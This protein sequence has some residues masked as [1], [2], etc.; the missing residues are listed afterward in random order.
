[1]IGLQLYVENQLVEMFDDESVTLTQTIQDVRN[2]DKIFSDFSKTFSVPASETNNKIFK[3]F[4]NFEILNGF[5]ARVK[6]DAELYLNYKLFK[7]GKV[8]L[9]G[10]T[11]KINKPHTYK[12]TF[13]G[14]TV[15]LKDKIGDSTLSDLPILT[16]LEFEYTDASIKGMLNTAQ[17]KTMNGVV[18]PEVLLVPL[19]THTKRLI[20]DSSSSTLNT[21]T[22]ANIAYAAGQNKGVEFDQLKPAIRVHAI[23]KAIE[24]EFFTQQGFSFSKDFFATSNASYYNL[25]LWLHN[26]VGS[27]FSDQPEQIK[28]T[29]YQRVFN[30]SPDSN[31]FTLNKNSFINLSSFSE[32]RFSVK[33]TNQTAKYNVYLFKN[34]EL[35]LEYKDLVG[36]TFPTQGQGKGKKGN[37]DFIPLA[38]G[39]FTFAVES[40][41]V[42]TFEISPRVRSGRGSLDVFF[43]IGFTGTAISIT[44]KKVQ[45]TE[46]LPKIKIIDFLTGIFKMFNLTA[47]I[48]DNKTIKIQTLDDFYDTN[49]TF[50]DVT[51]FI[52]KESSMVDSVLPYKQIN[53]SYKGDKSFMAANFEQ[54]YNRKWGSLKYDA[55]FKSESKEL[56]EFEGQVYEIKLPFDHFMFERL[57]NVSGNANTAVQWG[58]S[59]DDKQGAYLPEPLLFYP[60]LNSGTSIGVLDSANNVS[61]VTSYFVPSNSL[62]LSNSLSDDSSDNINFNSETNEYEGIPFNKSLFEKYYKSYIEDVFDKRRR[63]TKVKA[64]L[65]VSILQNLTLA[66]KLVIFNK[67]YKINKIVTNFETLL[68]DLELI[69]TTTEITPIIPSKFLPVSTDTNL[70]ADSDEFFADNGIITVDKFNNFEGLEVISTTE[71]VPEDVS[72]PNIPQ[73]VISDE[74]LTV[75]PP[76]LTYLTTAPTSSVVTI[77]FTVT[78]LGKVGS[79]S[80][81]DE[82]GFF[83]STTKSH[84]SSDSITTLKAGS[85]TNIKYDTTPQNKNTLSGNIKYQ[86]TGLSAGDTI[87]YRFYGK[88]TNDTSFDV[89]SGEML[90]SVLFEQATPSISFTTTTSV[91]SYH[92]MKP[93]GSAFATGNSTFRI[94]NGDGTFFDVKGI[95]GGV[96][97]SFVVP[98]LIEGDAVSFQ[99]RFQGVDFTGI[100]VHDTGYQYDK[101]S[102]KQFDRELDACGYHAT[103]RATAE[104][105][106]RSFSATGSTLPNGKKLTKLGFYNQG[107]SSETDFVCQNYRP[108][109]EGYGLYQIPDDQFGVY[110]RNTES[111][112]LL[113]A[114]DGFYAFYD[115][116][117]N[118]CYAPGQGVSGSVVDGIVTNVK[119]FY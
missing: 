119:T 41:T 103:D 80:Q 116:N 35:E 39:N 5:D 16:D 50:T 82:Y 112:K 60:V 54:I 31:F 104:S 38:K 57:K 102:Q 4:Y 89:A 59:A 17:S 85:A 118:G 11:L 27:M 71:V 29:N 110:Q 74:A 23:I 96:L 26:K 76:T 68:S 42:A 65:P 117:Q 22:L 32:I 40:D 98:V 19:M 58:W 108:L 21:D 92:V 47:F 1:M 97:Y 44:N 24:R 70:S 94:K 7:K 18:F 111:N 73:V 75:T 20:Y 53:F 84:L 109:K 45:I 43:N 9:E 107:A 3:H 90:S 36:D 105:Y 66:D 48:Q 67:T 55:S 99:Q 14:N 56:E 28:F 114:P 106:A 6:V 87:Y 77:S 51:E 78:T 25:F 15:N 33:T 2:I 86:I 113:Y 91:Y 72:V 100:A 88:T 83:Y 63:L 12:L 10:T 46:Q 8:K 95:S 62:Y 93:D 52:D 79:T 69:N 101:E 30:S 61:E 37:A 64:Y 13:F 34:G 81:I 49:T 115:S